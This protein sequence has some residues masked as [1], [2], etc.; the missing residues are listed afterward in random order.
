MSVM[1]SILEAE[2]K[3]K[4]L[5]DDAN[6]KAFDILSKS[7]E[8]ALL[9]EKKIIDNTKITIEKLYKDFEIEKNNLLDQA[10]KDTDESLK[11]LDKIYNKNVNK[12]KE[13][14]LKDIL[15]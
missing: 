1:N 4:K 15:K 13:I 11:E 12:V 7:K 9:E 14:I 3:A 8:E 2:A 5:K 6:K 10:K